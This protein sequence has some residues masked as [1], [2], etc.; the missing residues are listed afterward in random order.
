[1][2]PDG[3]V[4]GTGAQLVVAGSTTNLPSGIFQRANGLYLETTSSVYV[5]P[6]SLSTIGTAANTCTNWTDPATPSAAPNVGYA[7][8]AT[9]AAFNATTGDCSTA[10]LL[11]CV[12]Q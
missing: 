4:I 8:F 10:R 2:R 9:G 1:M 3:V 6:A 7:N 11:Y 5:G 12:E